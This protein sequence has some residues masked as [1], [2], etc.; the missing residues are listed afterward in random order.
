MYGQLSGQF[1]D[2]GENN[3]IQA[4]E[5]PEGTEEDEFGATKPS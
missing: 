2:T 5:V 4:D 1:D 3:D